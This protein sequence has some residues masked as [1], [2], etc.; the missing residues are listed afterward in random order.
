[1]DGWTITFKNNGQQSLIGCVTMPMLTARFCAGRRQY[2]GKQN[3]TV[4]SPTQE[5]QSI[6]PTRFGSFNL[7]YNGRSRPRWR[8]IAMLRGCPVGLCALAG[9]A[10]MRPW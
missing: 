4:S 3:L 1:M 7:S 9:I 8:T 2:P 6:T 5:I 10:W